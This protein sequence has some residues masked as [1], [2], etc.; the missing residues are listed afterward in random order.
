ML[1]QTN[2]LIYFEIICHY[3][4]TLSFDFGLAKQDVLISMANVIN[5][6]NIHEIYFF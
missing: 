5:I 1:Y 6:L 2:I 3:I 4:Q